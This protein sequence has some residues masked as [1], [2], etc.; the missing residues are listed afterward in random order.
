MER[1]MACARAG[2]LELALATSAAETASARSMGEAEATRE[3]LEVSELKQELATTRL[4][5][6]KAA[7]AASK[8]AASVRAETL[9]AEGLREEEEA[10]H[11]RILDEVLLDRETLQLAH[12]E[13][14][15]N[16]EAAFESQS[17]YEDT[18]G[19]L[20]DD[21]AEAIKG[22]KGGVSDVGTLRSILARLPLRRG[23]GGR[24]Y[25][26][27]DN[28]L[29]IRLAAC[30]ASS[31]A[32]VDI[33]RLIMMHVF[34]DDAKE[35]VAWEA[36]SPSLLDSRRGAISSVNDQI[37]GGHLPRLR[38]GTSWGTIRPR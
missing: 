33:Y 4:E 16:S 9:L 27:D 18:I 32:L 34:E 30:N 13:L 1:K 15:S 6:I 2:E 8:L 35:G 25:S 26:E 3:A 7:A 22:A 20:K 31:T 28:K 21:L 23:E 29:F 14:R 12:D 37:G 10:A 19:S 24:V 11:S 38:L 5:L 36:P 17:Y